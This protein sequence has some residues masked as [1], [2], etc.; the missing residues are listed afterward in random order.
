MGSRGPKPAPTALRLLSGERRPSRI[1]FAEPKIAAPKSMQPPS[2]LH[3]AGLREWTR[4]AQLLVDAGVL[5]ATDLAAFEDYCRALSDLRRYEA[6]AARAGLELSIAKGFASQVL[7]L[8]GQVAQLRNAI[9]LTPTSR[10]GVKAT[11]PSKST[12]VDAFRN[13]QPGR[14]A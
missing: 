6:K 3:G 2:G 9:G 8:R 14:P 1:N 4:L 13:R 12:A 7:K 11:P 10:T 5:R